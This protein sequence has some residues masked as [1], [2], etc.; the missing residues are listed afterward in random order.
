[1]VL[2]RQTIVC[3]LLAILEEG[4]G[5]V[6]VARIL[7]ALRI[8]REVALDVKSGRSG[9]TK[10]QRETLDFLERFVAANG[11]PPTVRQICAALGLSSTQTA[12]AH[13]CKLERK[14]CLRLNRAHR[15]IQLLTD[16]NRGASS[17]EDAGSAGSRGLNGVGAGLRQVP[18]IGRVAAG[19]P[20]LALE[21]IE[22][23]VDL[24]GIGSDPEVFA[25]RVRGDSMVEAGIIDGDLILV[26][27]QETAE[28]GDIVV[29]LLRDEATVKFF[30]RER[31]RVRL[32]PA[33]SKMK[34]IF[35]KEVKLI[36]KVI[37]SLRGYGATSLIKATVNE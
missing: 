4:E 11:Y 7:A 24:G 23:Y 18:L 20:V 13:L 28:N 27:R 3:M 30:F 16:W 17:G 15:S 1:M 35:A 33:N 34:P 36:G 21:N 19:Q 14:G 12:Y 6:G 10:R 2:A 25:L 9:L 5:L 8:D 37:A 29:A 22:G 31:R 26:R 32:Q